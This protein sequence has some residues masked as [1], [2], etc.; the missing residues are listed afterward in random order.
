MSWY[1]YIASNDA[2]ISEQR[3]GN[4]VEQVAVD[5]PQPWRKLEYRIRMHI[6]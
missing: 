4:F 5:F 2:V 1:D 6:M 3:F